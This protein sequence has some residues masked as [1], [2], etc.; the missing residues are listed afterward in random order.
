MLGSHKSKPIFIESRRW[1][2]FTAVGS[3]SMEVAASMADA[4]AGV[5]VK[6]YETIKEHQTRTKISLESGSSQA[7][8]QDD[9]ACV[10]ESGV[11]RRAVG[12]STKSLGKLA[13][14]SAKGIFVDIPIAVTDGLRAV[15]NLY[16]EDVRSRDH[17]TG[18]R[19]GAVVAGKNFCH[20]IFE[21]LTDIAVYTYHGKR[22]ENALGAAKGLGKGALSLVTKT[23][24]ATIG[25]VAYPA[26]GIHRSIRAAVVTSTPKA[27]E[28]AMRIEGDWLLKK[29]P[30]SEE[31][32]RCTVADFETLRNS[33]PTKVVPG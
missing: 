1:D 6:P 11:A 25:L 21:A 14:T 15:P 28:A 7:R 22:E 18:F 17:I 31:E 4:T 20:G 23:T 16:G 5:F 8:S 19:S 27:I 33:K 24:A 9:S 13:V 2:P 30:V 26:Q 12:T 10:T 3:A 32:T 29:K